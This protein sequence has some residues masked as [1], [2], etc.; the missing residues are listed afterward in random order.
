MME[1]MELVSG[2]LLDSLGVTKADPPKSVRGRATG[3]SSFS[4]ST[5]SKQPSVGSFSVLMSCLSL[6]FS[7]SH[8]YISDAVFH[9]SR[10]AELEW[11]GEPFWVIQVPGGCRK[12]GMQRIPFGVVTVTGLEVQGPLVATIEASSSLKQSP[13]ADVP[14]LLKTGVFRASS[15]SSGS[16]SLRAPGDTLGQWFPIPRRNTDMSPEFSWALL[17]RPTVSAD[18]NTRCSPV[19]GVL[20]GSK[21]MLLVMLVMDQL[22]PLSSRDA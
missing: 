1:A 2:M 12:R 13:V 15:Y 22:S 5:P 3:L 17:G 10:G 14:T 4:C 9:P 6:V 21:A 8:L 16:W 20:S 18:L 7:A 19:F 11:R